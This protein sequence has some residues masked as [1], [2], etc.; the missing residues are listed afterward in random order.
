MKEYKDIEGQI[1][2]TYLCDAC[3]KVLKG[4]IFHFRGVYYCQKCFDKYQNEGR[5]K[6][7]G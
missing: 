2:V 7:N 5:L 6:E 3:R 1:R 4:K